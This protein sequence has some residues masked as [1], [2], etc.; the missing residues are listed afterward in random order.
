VLLCVDSDTFTRQAVE[1]G[2]YRRH[3]QP[4]GKDVLAKLR[5][6]RILDAVR[7]HGAVRVVELSQRLEVSEMT[8]RRDLGT[9]AAQGLVQKVHGGA[10]AVTERSID[11]PGFAAK[12]VRQQAEKEAIAEAAALLVAPGSAVALTGGTTTWALARRLSSLSG[13]TVVTNSVPVADELRRA[14]DGSSVVL[15]GGTRTPSD[16]LVG[17]IA[18]SA[19][20]E[21]HV[22][23]VFMGVH[24][25]DEAA[26]FTTPNLMECEINRAFLQSARRL[27][28]L[29]DHTKWG[30]IGLSSIADLGDADV[31]ISDASLP[32]RACEI[33][34][35]R[36]GRLVIAE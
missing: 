4:G 1:V 28:V 20:R 23:V 29:A 17:P 5:Q 8:V 13:L 35:E 12:S 21:L 33:L 31:L 10:T 26:G 2:A 36:V 9:L 16:A 24:G 15:T 30:L 11:E 7:E 14:A 18:E 22:D 6:G 34:H 27:V 3:P 32:P 19:A 25:M